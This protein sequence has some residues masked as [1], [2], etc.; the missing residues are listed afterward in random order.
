MPRFAE[1]CQEKIKIGQK[2]PKKISEK[3]FGQKKGGTLASTPERRNYVLLSV[4]LV[5]QVRDK[6]SQ[7]VEHCKSY[8][9]SQDAQ[10]K[11]YDE[12]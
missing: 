10:A 1:S 9:E 2:N 5:K 6:D 3:D 8:C 7:E 12:I 4:E 11:C